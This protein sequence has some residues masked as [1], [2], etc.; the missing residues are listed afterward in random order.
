MVHILAAL[1]KP[2]A[3]HVEIAGEDTDD[4]TDD[5]LA[6]LRAFHIGVVFQRFFLLDGLDAIDN[7]A[8][9]LLYRAVTWLAL[10]RRVSASYPH[11]MRGRSEERRVGK[12]CV[13]LCRS[14]WSPYH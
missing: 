1:E 12:E 2:T 11:A 13:F 14:R 10:A 7:V 8:M 3:G 4:L 9:G 5:A 6:A